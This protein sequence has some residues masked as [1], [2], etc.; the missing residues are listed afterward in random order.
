MTGSQ[1]TH[2]CVGKTSGHQGGAE[3]RREGPQS[4]K[5]KRKRKWLDPDW[6]DVCGHMAWQKYSIQQEGS[7]SEASGV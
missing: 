6:K 3:R 4:Q 5:K 1:G 7:A 2:E